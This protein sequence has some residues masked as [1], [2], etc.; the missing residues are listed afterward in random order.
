MASDADHSGDDPISE[1][2]GNSARASA[3]VPQAWPEALPRASE[4]EFPMPPTGHIA[5]ETGNDARASE[6]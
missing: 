2:T 4:E 3:V 1:E 5:K 6:D